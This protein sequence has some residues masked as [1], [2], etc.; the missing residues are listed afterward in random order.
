MDLEDGFDDDVQ[1]I[2]SPGESITS[3]HAFMR[4]VYVHFPP[5]YRSSS[6]GATEH[7][8]TMR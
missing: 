7:M 2:T 3:S 6:V 5:I 1:R 8:F 4:Y